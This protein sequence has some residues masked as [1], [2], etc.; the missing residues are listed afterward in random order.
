ML[1]INRNFD[2]LSLNSFFP[3]T[4]FCTFYLWKVRNE[5]GSWETI[6]VPECLKYEVEKTV[7]IK[8]RKKNALG[9]YSS[10]YEDYALIGF[11]DQ[12]K[13]DIINEMNKMKKEGYSRSKP[14][15]IEIRDRGKLKNQ[16][17]VKIS[18]YRNFSITTER[19]WEIY[20]NAR[21]HI[22]NID[23]IYSSNHNKKI[24]RSY[25]NQYLERKKLKS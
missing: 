13:N 4:D 3:V 22:P 7:G 15:C 2:S 19:R 5:S 23:K 18:T 16:F 24:V 11:S 17:S 1:N 14:L 10:M 6:I 12:S 20:H 8:L 21:N 9:L 25:I